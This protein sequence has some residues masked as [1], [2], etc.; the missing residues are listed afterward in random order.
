MK[1]SILARIKHGVS[2]IKSRAREVGSAR[3]LP[4][5]IHLSDML[6]ADMTFKKKV[7]F[8]IVSKN[9]MHYALALRESFLRHN[10][11]YRFVIVLMDMYDDQGELEVFTDL[12][13]RGVEIMNFNSLRMLPFASNNFDSMLAKYN[14]LEMNTAIKPFV[15]EEFF[16]QGHEQVTYIDPDIYFYASLTIVEEG[17]KENDF[18]LT[19]HITE[20]YG[21][22]KHPS[23]IDIMRSGAYNLGFIALN[24]SEQSYEMVRWWQACLAEWCYSRPSAGLFTD[25]KWMDLLPC[26][27]D[28]VKVEKNSG[29]NVAYWNLHE[30]VI[31]S[32]A[33][34]WKVN[35]TALVFFH[36]SGLPLTGSGPLSKH[37]NRFDIDSISS[38]SSLVAEYRNSVKAFGP[39]KFLKYQY[40]FRNY[41]GSKIL[42]IPD[43]LRTTLMIDIYEKFGSPFKGCLILKNQITDYLNDSISENYS[44]SRLRHSIWSSREDLKVAFRDI[45]T[46]ESA[47]SPFQRLVRSV[48]SA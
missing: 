10:N 20:P 26:L 1:V 47:R 33:G 30:R 42:S 16:N 13:R 22:E 25:Q 11:D 44:L 34:T 19:P 4:S 15:I 2:H 35:G 31:T 45:L 14:I 17:L 9:Y 37:Q 24:R 21:D 43:M 28:K 5:T 32:E 38:V 39:G 40:H 8:T 3:R 46:D 18:I 7:A 6:K 12:Q 36:F 41:G 29:L 23:E 48:G 27:F